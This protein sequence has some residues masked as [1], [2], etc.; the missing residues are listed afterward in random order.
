MPTLERALQIAVQAH[1]GQKE[2]T[3]EAYIFHPIRVMMRCRSP[4]AKIAG[5]LHDVVEDTP[6]TRQLTRVSRRTKAMKTKLRIV[7]IVTLSVLSLAAAFLFG[8]SLLHHV[9]RAAT[10][11]TELQL[12]QAEW[13]RI[14]QLGPQALNGPNRE[15][16]QRYSAEVYRWFRVRGMID[17]TC[18]DTAPTREWREL[19]VYFT[20]GHHAARPPELASTQ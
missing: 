19:I 14:V 11:T 13:A 7:F 18:E 1:S 6:V 9:L 5:L 16:F 8:P 15:S 17:P 2:K 10:Q 4:E 12:H 3:G 20:G